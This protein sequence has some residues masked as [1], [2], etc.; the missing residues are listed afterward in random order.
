MVISPLSRSKFGLLLGFLIVA[1]II[2]TV[3]RCTDH[4]KGI[5]KKSMRKETRR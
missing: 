1:L 2:G 5:H 4:S 3:D